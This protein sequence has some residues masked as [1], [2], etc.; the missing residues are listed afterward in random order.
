MRLKRKSAVATALSAVLMAALVLLGLTTTSSS[1][2]HP[3]TRVHTKSV[4]Q[5]ITVSHVSNTDGEGLYLHEDSPTIG[6]STYY[7][8]PDGTEFDISCWSPGDD[9]EGDVVWEYGED[10]QTGDSGYAADKFLD[11]PVTMGQEEAQLSAM[12]VPQCGDGSTSNDA[13]ASSSDDAWVPYCGPSK[14]VDVITVSRYAN[15]AFTIDLEPNLAARTALDATAATNEEW[16]AVQDCVSGLY[17]SLADS[18][19]E[20][21]N[22]HQHLALTPNTDGGFETGSS[23][24]LDSWRPVFPDDLSH[25]VSTRCGNSLGTDPSGD[26]VYT[27]RPDDGV[28]DEGVPANLS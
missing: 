28:T 20:Q 17:G 27:G 23:Y 6:S 22:C 26:P 3:H 14:Y 11:T 24:G 7:T 19:Y 1:L 10:M 25:W 9:V 5:V 2:H 12:G 8:M 13:S 15:G 4:S 16:H 21:I 18:I